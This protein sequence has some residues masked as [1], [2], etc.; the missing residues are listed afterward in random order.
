MFWSIDQFYLKSVNRTLLNQV[1]FEFN[2][3]LCV[4]AASVLT[5][6][7]LSSTASQDSQNNIVFEDFANIRRG[8]SADQP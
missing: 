7:S 8:M 2:Y 3:Y 4:L 5:K 6:P 1:P